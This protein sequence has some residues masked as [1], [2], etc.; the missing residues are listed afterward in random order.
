MTSPE[1]TRKPHRSLS[2]HITSSS[3]SPGPKYVQNAQKRKLR[4][5][6]FLEQQVESNTLKVQKQFL[7]YQGALTLLDFLKIH[8]HF[9]RI[10]I[11]G[12]NIS[13]QSFALICRQLMAFE[14]LHTLKADS[15]AIGK[16]H[17]GL[18]ALAEL[19]AA[20]P[21]L[22]VIDLRKNKIGSKCAE[23][24]ANIIEE[25]PHLQKLDL[26]WNDI[27]DNEALYILESLRRHPRT[28]QI[29]L[30][31]NKLE[32][33]KI[34]EDI[35]F[36]INEV[37]VAAQR[38]VDSTARD[39]QSREVTLGSEKPGNYLSTKKRSKSPVGF[40]SKD[41][42]AHSPNISRKLYNEYS[43]INS[44]ERLINQQK[45]HQSKKR[46]QHDDSGDE[47]ASVGWIS[48][49]AA[50]LVN[51]FESRRKLSP[52][53]NRKATYGSEERKKSLRQPLSN[54]ANAANMASKGKEERLPSEEFEQN[55][56]SSATIKKLQ[57]L[58]THERQRNEHMSE[59][60]K[61]QIETELHY[62]R[63]NRLE[64]ER[65]NA[66]LA[67]E[68]KE[69]DIKF[70]ELQLNHRKLAQTCAQLKEANA[71][72]NAELAKLSES[73]RSK[74]RA[75]EEADA[76]TIADYQAE[77]QR[78][79]RQ[80]RELKN[81]IQL[82]S[83]QY[84]QKIKD[85]EAK[86]RQEERQRYE[87]ELGRLRVS[88]SPSPV[89]S[90]RVGLEQ[91]CERL[92]NENKSLK[93]LAERLKTQ[94]AE[95]LTRNDKMKH[96]LNQLEGVVAKLE[97]DINQ[98]YVEMDQARE[99]HHKELGAVLEDHKA[100]RMKWHEHEIM[101]KTKLQE[102]EARIIKAEVESEKMNQKIKRLVSSLQGNVTKAISMTFLESGE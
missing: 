57:Q 3:L 56:R 44:L 77:N 78:L 42:N 15:N 13:S 8:T 45:K 10:D 98:A 32:G 97:N 82:V 37:V 84:R 75:A 14:N 12:N 63:R 50:H 62:E 2:G 91:E 93:L 74:R 88:R 69:R 4:L 5:Q 58:L 22:R 70:N 65:R 26:R 20:L 85:T 96:E 92:S 1:Q 47:S 48:R 18:D 29:F 38:G 54:V 46:N 31:G 19:V 59:L 34:S 17:A 86:V 67:T 51:K 23:A 55:L 87:E 81:E 24:L 76:E 33:N 25:G 60:I 21:S 100:E 39:V 95:S 94:L 16:A 72:L 102:Q 68:I 30:G 71:K 79:E 66:Q 6:E 11:S 40:S 80:I 35:L 83:A 64:A 52:Y 49:S 101:L 7:D 89:K 41:S 99:L 27:G 9:T 53:E 90:N 28:L 43:N 36:A 61:E 73:S